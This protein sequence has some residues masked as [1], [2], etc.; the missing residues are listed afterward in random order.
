MRS[1]WNNNFYKTQ[2]ALS[3]IYRLDMSNFGEP[4]TDDDKKELSEAIISVS[5]GKRE[6]EFVPVYFG[7]V[8]S[9]IFTRAKT[10][11]SF[12]IK[13]SENKDFSITDT[14]EYL[15]NYENMNQDYPESDRGNSSY[16]YHSTQNEEYSSINSRIITIKIYDPNG[17][18]SVDAID[19]GLIAKL[20][21]Y[22]CKIASIGD[23]EFSYESTEAITRDI[24][25]FYNYMRYFS[26]IDLVTEE[27][28]EPN[29]GER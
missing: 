9:K 14:F 7:G 11:D 29:E 2:P 17:L 16:N 24:T 27:P 5:L 8:E 12:T 4:I 19:D 1:I 22:G 13:F 18:P 28:E 26:G 25:F 3:W 20:S 15:Y 21:F 10:S 6:S 23:I